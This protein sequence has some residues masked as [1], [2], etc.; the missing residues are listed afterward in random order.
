MLDDVQH[1]GNEFEL[2]ADLFADA[3]AQLAA[4]GAALLVVG[5]VVDHLLAGQVLRQRA[6]AM[7]LAGGAPGLAVIRRLRFFRL[8][9][10]FDQVGGEQHELL[11]I[12]PVGPRAVASLEQLLELMLERLDPTLLAV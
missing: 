8:R 12:E 1:G 3:L 11:G 4:A 6:T 2:F 9:G 10:L 7:P 5:Q